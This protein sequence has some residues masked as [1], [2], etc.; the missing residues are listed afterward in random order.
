MKA[1]AFWQLLASVREAE[2]IRR[3]TERALALANVWV[4][5]RQDDVRASRTIVSRESAR[6]IG[7]SFAGPT[8]NTADAHRPAALALL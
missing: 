5:W 1:P 4:R 8:M 6:I 2:G 7:R 3:S